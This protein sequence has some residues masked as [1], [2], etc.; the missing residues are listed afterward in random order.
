[1]SKVN[2]SFEGLDELRTR[3]ESMANSEEIKQRALESSGEHLREAIAKS[4]PVRTGALKAAIIKGE[5]QDGKI[6]IGPSRQGPAFRAHF[7]EFGTSKMRAKPFLR[8]T[9]EQEKDT[10]QKIMADE[11]R[12]GLGL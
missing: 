10:V 1:M 9:F 4:V 3:L 12:K 2:V 8:P 6:L 7:V 5:V 11:I